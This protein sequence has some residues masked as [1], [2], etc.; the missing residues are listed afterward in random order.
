MIELI[1]KEKMNRILLKLFAAISLLASMQVHAQSMVK[2]YDV[3]NAASAPDGSIDSNFYTGSVTSGT[4]GFNYTG[5]SGTL[6]DGITDGTTSQ[7]IQGG[8]ATMVTLHLSGKTILSGIDIWGAPAFWDPFQSMLSNV[9]V[10]INGQS[11]L[12]TSAG[13]NCAVGICQAINSFSGTI[14]DGIV[15]D[16]VVLGRFMSHAYDRSFRINEITV[17]GVSAVPEPETYAMM[18]LGLGVIGF[19]A[20]RAKRTT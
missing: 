16:T 7:L 19:T 12:F 6:N 10:T 11:L 18:L 1:V 15:T 8:G 3:I 20:R 14:F 2:T 4:G 17:N 9:S 13:R 5:G